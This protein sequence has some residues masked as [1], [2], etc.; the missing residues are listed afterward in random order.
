MRYF[1]SNCLLVPL[2]LKIKYDIKIKC[3][4][5][6]KYKIPHFYYIHNNAKYNFSPLYNKYN[7]FKLNGIPYLFYK[8]KIMKIK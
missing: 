3:L 8:A 4:F 2:I 5:N 7:S 1:Y 6:R